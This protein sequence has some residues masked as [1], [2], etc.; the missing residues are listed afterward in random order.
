[1]LLLKSLI[2][3]RLWVQIFV[4]ENANAADRV[5]V[6]R[7]AFVFFLGCLKS[8]QLIL[9]PLWQGAATRLF[10]LLPCVHPNSGNSPKSIGCLITGGF[11]L[12]R[13]DASAL[14]LDFP[15]KRT[16]A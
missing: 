14:I 1:M 11:F 3:Q 13:G 4:I 5:F 7:S 6:F 8:A 2:T 9:Q 12:L 16:K 15:L 10:L